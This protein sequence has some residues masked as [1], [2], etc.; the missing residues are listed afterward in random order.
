[1]KFSHLSG[2][3]A[4]DVWEFRELLEFRLGFFRALINGICRPSEL[5]WLR[6]PGKVSPM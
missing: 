3:E 5:S 6:A 2:V 1:M 4:K